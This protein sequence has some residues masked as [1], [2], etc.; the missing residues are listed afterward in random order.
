M[1]ISLLGTGE[2]LIYPHVPEQDIMLLPIANKTLLSQQISAIPQA[3]LGPIRN[4]IIWES[5]L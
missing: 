3:D 1:E 4:S 5:C 2:K